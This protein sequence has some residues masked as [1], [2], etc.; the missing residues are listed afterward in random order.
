MHTLRTSWVETNR[1]SARVSEKM[2][3]RISAEIK[4]EPT[5]SEKIKRPVVSAR[6]SAADY[7]RSE[8]L[9]VDVQDVG[10]QLLNMLS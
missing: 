2:G 1:A 4:E 3:Y 9:R 7:H 5:G 6:L 8:G 10:D